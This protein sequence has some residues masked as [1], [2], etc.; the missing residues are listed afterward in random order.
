MQV[1]FL[2]I[3][4]VVGAAILWFINKD[5]VDASVVE[6]E[7]QKVLNQAEGEFEARKQELIASLTREYENQA[8]EKNC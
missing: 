1:L 7:K 3:G 6:A 8:N 4:L 2:L 5:K